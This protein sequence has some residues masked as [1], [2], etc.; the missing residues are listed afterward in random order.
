MAFCYIELSEDDI[1]R[2]IKIL[3]SY[4]LIRNIFTKTKYSINF[5]YKLS[6]HISFN[7]IEYIEIIVK[8]SKCN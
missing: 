6:N 3:N 4:E 5:F 8:I 7:L 2:N 1:L